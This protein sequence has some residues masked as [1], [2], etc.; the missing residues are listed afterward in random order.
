MAALRSR[1]VDALLGVSLDTAEYGHFEALASAQVSESFDLDFKAGLCGSAEKGK[2]GLAADVAALA[3]TAGGL[4][5]LDITEDKQARAAAA[6]GVTISDDE[7]RRIHQIAASL[8]AP[9]PVFDVL[10]VGNPVEPG[11]GLLV[12]AVPASPRAVTVNEGLRFPVRHGTTTRYLSEPE[13]ATAYRERFSRAYGTAE[14]ARL[15]ETNAAW[16]MKRADDHCWLLISLVPDIL[17][18]LLIDHAALAAAQRDVSLSRFPMIIHSN[19]S[20]H[21][22]AVGWRCLI[23]IDSPESSR[24]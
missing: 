8:V 12:I 9:L 17:S 10:P 20:C 6:P 23:M 2:H 22:V 4:L 5:I 24:L 13:V 21:R 1:R 16:R 3:N 14:R 15:I 11:H 18:D 7:I 19:F